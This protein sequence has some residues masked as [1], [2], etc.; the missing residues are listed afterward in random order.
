MNF[1]DIEF[2]YKEKLYNK[3]NIIYHNDDM[4]N[5]KYI[6]LISRINNIDGCIKIYDNEKTY[7][8]N[9]MKN[10]KHLLYCND[11]ELIYITEKQFKFSKFYKKHLENISKIL[12]NRV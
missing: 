6:C 12:L 9:K 8:D 2:L 4:F 1:D 3:L 5:K 7:T 11:D 10:I